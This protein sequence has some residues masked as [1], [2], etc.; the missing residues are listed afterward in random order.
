MFSLGGRINNRLA[1][2]ILIVYNRF[3][4]LFH[5]VFNHGS[6][7]FHFHLAVFFFLLFA[8]HTLLGSYMLSIYNLFLYLAIFLGFKLWLNLILF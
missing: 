8:M 1:L 7:C 5:W 2:W 6:D 4:F 3:V